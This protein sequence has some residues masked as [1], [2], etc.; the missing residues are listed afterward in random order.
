LWHVLTYKAWIITSVASSKK[1]N[2]SKCY[3]Q[4][5]TQV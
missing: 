1:Q 5:T 3:Y 2:L 4:L